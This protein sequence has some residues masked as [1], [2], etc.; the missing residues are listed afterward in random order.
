MLSDTTILLGTCDSFLRIAEVSVGLL[1]M[2]WPYHPPILAACERKVLSAASQSVCYW[3]NNP[4]DWTKRMLVA[5]QH[6]QTRYVLMWLDDYLLIEPPNQDLLAAAW[7]A[8][9][10]DGNIGRIDFNQCLPDG[11]EAYDRDD[12]F[13]KHP[14]WLWCMNT[15]AALWKRESLLR[16]L[17]ALPGNDIWRFE[18]AAADMQNTGQLDAYQLATKERA[19]HYA[20]LVA[21]GKLRSRGDLEVATRNGFLLTEADFPRG[22]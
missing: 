21:L 1:D 7:A 22:F 19:M 11:S 14:K 13:L 15:Q 18:L 8:H 9:E 10:N 17:K 16:V 3:T 2:F 4:K 12:R 20:N 5:C 6:I